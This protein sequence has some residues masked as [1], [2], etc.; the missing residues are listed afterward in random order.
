MLQA[1]IIGTLCTLDMMFLSTKPL[2]GT[3]TIALRVLGLSIARLVIS[4]PVLISTELMQ[5]VMVHTAL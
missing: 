1:I 2:N 4:H 5:V 3:V